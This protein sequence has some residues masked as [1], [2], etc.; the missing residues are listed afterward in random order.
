LQLV[1]LV[2]DDS[3]DDIRIDPWRRLLV[4]AFLFGCHGWLCFLV[5]DGCAHVQNE[6][7]L[8]VQNF[9]HL[10]Q[11]LLVKFELAVQFCIDSPLPKGFLEVVVGSFTDE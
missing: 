7:V 8:R 4:I 6:L 10:V 1:L 5:K 2:L 9:L 11:L 3:L